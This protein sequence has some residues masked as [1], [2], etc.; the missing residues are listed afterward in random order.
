MADAIDNLRFELR[1]L[2]AK[3]A[4]DS[5]KIQSAHQPIMRELRGGKYLLRVQLR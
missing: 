5:Q 4:Q 2:L 3:L 1:L